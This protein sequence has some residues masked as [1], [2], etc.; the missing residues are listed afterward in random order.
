MVRPEGSILYFNVDHVRDS[1]FAILRAQPDAPRQVI[2]F[3]GNVPHVDF[4]GAEL[5]VHLREDF[6]ARK[7]EFGLAETHGEVP[8]ALQRLGGN[9]SAG[10]DAANQ[11]VDDVLRRWKGSGVT[12]SGE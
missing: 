7:I 11:T 3:M 1:L 2:L 10:L 9:Q 5:L 4:A 8:E 12:T 6:R